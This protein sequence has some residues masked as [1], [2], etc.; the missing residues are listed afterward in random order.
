MTMRELGKK[1]RAT[2]S[3]ANQSLCAKRVNNGKLSE[4]LIRRGAR[5]SGILRHF[6]KFPAD[7]MRE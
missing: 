3:A 6:R 4:A 1:W 5:T 7:P 2:Q